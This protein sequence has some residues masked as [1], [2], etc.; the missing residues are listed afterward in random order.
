MQYCRELPVIYRANYGQFT[1]NYVGDPI[2]H[3]SSK[4]ETPASL[5]HVCL[6]NQMYH[7]QFSTEL[8]L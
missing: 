6:N 3:F 7:Q 8:L 4:I 5:E 2:F 1:H